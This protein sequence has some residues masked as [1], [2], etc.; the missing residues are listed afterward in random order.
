MGILPENYFSG[1]SKRERYFILIIFILLFL[2]FLFKKD[3]LLI[4]KP[5]ITP[6]SEERNTPPETLGISRSEKKC[7]IKQFS[8]DDWNTSRFYNNSDGFWCPRSTWSDPV[9]WLKNGIPL[10]S[11]RFY[12]EYEIIKDKKDSS[13]PPSLIVEYAQKKDLTENAREETLLPIY[14]LWTPE[15]SNNQLFRFSKNI[16][17]SS[18]ET[19]LENVLKP[20]EAYSLS[21]SVKSGTNNSLAITTTNMKGNE[22]NLNFTYNYTSAELDKGISDTVSKSIK[23]P[24]SDVESSNDSF[25]YGIGTFK[26]YCIRIVSYCS[27]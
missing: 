14:K 3:N 2:L 5:E 18:N 6:T 7:E 11:N 22:I 4:K 15:G 12:I 26:D 24:V 19:N 13:N 23:M 16:N 9:M 21:S 1:F 8:T 25:Y 10:K 27:D 17:Y 20:E